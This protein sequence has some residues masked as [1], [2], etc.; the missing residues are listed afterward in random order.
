MISVAT[1]C[2]GVTKTTPPI[3]TRS[4]ACSSRP[5]ARR[6]HQNWYAWSYRALAHNADSIVRYL[7]LNSDD[8]AITTLPLAYSFGMSILN[9]HLAAGASLTLTSHSILTKEFWHAA[10]TSGVTSLSGV[11]STFEMLRRA[12]I[13]RRGLSRIRMLTQA[14]GRLSDELTRVLLGPRPAVGVVVFRDVRTDGGRTTDQLCAASPVARED[15]E[16]RSGDTR[17]SG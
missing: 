5:R 13:E 16:H 10:A 12:G 9:S 17:R 15:R 14:G 11:P 1:A 8:R 2:S 6:D 3:P 7:G 4:V